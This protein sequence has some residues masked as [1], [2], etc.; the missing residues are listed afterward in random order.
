MLLD[1][2]HIFHIIA[3]TTS[4]HQQRGHCLTSQSNTNIFRSAGNPFHSSLS[5]NKLLMNSQ[6]RSHHGLG[7]FFQKSEQDSLKIDA[8]PNA[9]PTMS[10]HVEQ[11]HIYK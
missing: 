8:V 7:W 4:I 10:K 11:S 6:F 2:E 1:G 3:Q 9:E 5:E